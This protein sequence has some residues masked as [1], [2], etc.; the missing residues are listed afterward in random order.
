MTNIRATPVDAFR[1][2]TRLVMLA[3]DPGSVTITGKEGAVSLPFKPGDALLADANGNVIVPPF[4]P[5]GVLELAMRVLD[6]DER[7]LTN[8]HS[9]LVLSTALVAFPQAHA[10]PD[11]TP[12]DRKAAAHG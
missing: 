8:P 5:E 10:A 6:G 4:S 1:D 12:M 11:P 9:M 7:A 3:A 2:G